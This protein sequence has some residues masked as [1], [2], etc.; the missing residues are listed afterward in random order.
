M[1][2]ISNRLG[3]PPPSGGVH[4]CVMEAVAYG[5]KKVS[6]AHLMGYLVGVSVSLP[7]L[8][9]EA[10]GSRP[11]LGRVQRLSIRGPSSALR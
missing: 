6:L 10:E 3:A 11:S 9:G 8:Y 4:P 1:G 5:R 7:L 2:H